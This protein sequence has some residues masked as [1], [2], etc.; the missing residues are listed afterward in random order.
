MKRTEFLKHLK[1]HNCIIL[2]QG[3]NHTIYINLLNKK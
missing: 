1:K 3:A 2:R